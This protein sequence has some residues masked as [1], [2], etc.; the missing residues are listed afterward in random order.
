MFCHNSA[1]MQEAEWLIILELRTRGFRKL[2]W[3]TR[4]A[5]SFKANKEA[6]QFLTV[7]LMAESKGTLE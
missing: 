7:L 5:I 1:V 3:L 2:M 4:P 6:V